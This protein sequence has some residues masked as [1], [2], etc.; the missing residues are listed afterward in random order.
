[1]GIHKTYL[2]VVDQSDPVVTYM[3]RDFASDIA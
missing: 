3:S 1:M 2:I